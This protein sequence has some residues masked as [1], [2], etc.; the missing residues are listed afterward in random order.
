MSSAPADMEPE[1]ENGSPLP[2]TQP[3]PLPSSLHRDAPVAEQAVDESAS[4]KE[5][6]GSSQVLTQLNGDEVR[7][8]KMLVEVYTLEVSIMFPTYSSVYILLTWSRHGRA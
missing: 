3:Q 2:P 6:I 5:G 4:A 1:A 7:A 8:I